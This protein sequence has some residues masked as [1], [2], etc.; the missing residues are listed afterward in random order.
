VKNSREKV[1]KHKARGGSCFENLLCK[2]TFE[3]MSAVSGAEGGVR[4]GA[5][6]PSMILEIAKGQVS[7]GRLDQFLSE[8]IPFLSRSA[9]TKMVKEGY[10]T[11][12][13]T[14]GNQCTCFTSTK[15]QILTR[16][17]R[18]VGGGAQQRSRN[19][20]PKQKAVT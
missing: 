18:Q 13:S 12:T 15:V 3:R 10:V 4:S 6:K 5:Q 2:L 11:I 7:S 16:L 14:A 17:R 8:Q 1:K 9:I 19:L 20:L